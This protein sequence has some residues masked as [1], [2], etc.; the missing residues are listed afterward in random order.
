MIRVSL[1]PGTPYLD[2]DAALK[3][4]NGWGFALGEKEWLLPPGLK[5][6]LVDGGSGN[7]RAVFPEE[8]RERFSDGDGGEIE[9][10]FDVK[11]Y[12]V[13][14]PGSSLLES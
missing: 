13:E 5:W 2:I 11:Y 9:R 14:P 6:A 10:Y 8:I 4:S 12:T 7:Q 3:N 1:L